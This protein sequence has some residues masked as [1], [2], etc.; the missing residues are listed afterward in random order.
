MKLKLMA[1]FAIVAVLGIVS[2]LVTARIMAQR[3]PVPNP[4][5]PTGKTWIS[6]G[7]SQPIVP[8]GFAPEAAFVMQSVDVNVA[9]GVVHVKARGHIYDLRRGWDYVWSLRFIDPSDGDNTIFEKRYDTQIF[10]IPDSNETDITFDDTLTPP[11]NPGTYVVQALVYQIPPNLGL[12]HL[13]NAQAAKGLR[14]VSGS[15]KVTIGQ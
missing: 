12:A 11:L 15:R 5:V 6:T 2:S 1:K 8:P 3:S 13:D 10:R 4:Q 14:A 9:G 7:N